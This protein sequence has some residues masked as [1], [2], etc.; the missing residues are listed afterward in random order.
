MEWIGATFTRYPEL[1]VF[2]VVGIG[3]WVGAFKFL[4]FGLGPVTGSLLV[5][6]LLGCALPR[7]GVVHGEVDAVPAVPVQHRLLGR[8]EVLPAMRGD[9]LRYVG[10]G[11]R[12]G[13]HR[14][15][16]RLGIAHAF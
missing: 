14:P 11:G 5:G 9:G 10:A 4:G 6:L 2:L 15:R 16:D 1:A 3:Y 7:P 8:P 13:G 12:H